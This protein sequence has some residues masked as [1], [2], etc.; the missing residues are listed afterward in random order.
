M[1]TTRIIPILLIREQSLVKT[2][3]FSKHKYIGDPV[4]TVR[5]F[6]ELMVDELC[7]LDITRNNENKPNF[8]LLS[9]LADECFMPLSY[10]GGIQTM[11]QAK[12]IF[13]IGFEK[14]IVNSACYSEPNLISK[15]SEK[16][17]EQAVI[18]SIDVKKNIFGNYFVYSNNGNKRQ[19]ISPEHAAVYFEECGA[20][21]I[22]LTNIDREGTYSG[23]DTE[24][25]NKVSAA[26]SVPVIAN[27]GVG[28]LEHFKDGKRAGAS[29]LGA[30]SYFMF[31]KKDMG[32][33]IKYLTEQEKSSIDI[34]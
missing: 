32:V 12:S 6:N 7:L 24:I 18:V 16:Y 27:G 23:Y 25:I 9:K 2:Y 10:G 29:A 20:G 11:H 22:I 8:T 3:R 4:N 28:K 34:G 13:E 33:L 30:G 5:I 31:Q 1:L 26:V 17:G 21:E 19:A 14:I 15:L